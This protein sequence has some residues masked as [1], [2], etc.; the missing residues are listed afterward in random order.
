[1]SGLELIKNIRECSSEQHILITS[2]Y[3]DSDLLIDALNLAVEGYLIKPFDALISYIQRAESL[4]LMGRRLGITAG[5]SRFTA[6]GCCPCPV[7]P[8]SCSATPAPLEGGVGPALSGTLIGHI[9]LMQ[10][11]GPVHQAALI[12]AGEARLGGI[13]RDFN[14][15]PNRSPITMSTALRGAG[16]P[17]RTA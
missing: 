7:W 9:V 2:A 10:L 5:E 6:I 4:H 11:I 8:W 16:K 13:P 14:T 3:N 17:S 1:M 12:A 15:R